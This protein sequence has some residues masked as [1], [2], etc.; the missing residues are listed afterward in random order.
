MGLLVGHHLDAML[1]AAQKAI[2]LLQLLRRSGRYPPSGGEGV[3]HIQ[4]P[5]PAQRWVAAAGD[6]LLGLD[7]KLNFTDSA[8]P[9]LDVVTPDRNFAVPFHGMDLALQ[10]LN[11]GDCSKVEVLAPHV[12][13]EAL[14]EA[15]AKRQVAGHG[16]RLD[17]GG[18]PPV[19]P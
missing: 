12:R 18:T 8:A 2:I 17:H 1:D 19:L 4:R 3:K 13:F 6:E 10:G 14:Q 11:V 9:E 16:T 5:A 7:E 15:F